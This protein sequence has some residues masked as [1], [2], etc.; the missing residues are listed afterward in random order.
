M[1]GEFAPVTRV[2]SDRVG[3]DGTVRG[4]C[5]YAGSAGYGEVPVARVAEEALL[6]ST[7]A[8][9]VRGLR[10]SLHGSREPDSRSIRR[11]VQAFRPQPPIAGG[12][13]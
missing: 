10:C 4:A 3:L 8:N 9:Y 2:R 12:I 6:R 1:R 11:F 13:S 7:L 5:D